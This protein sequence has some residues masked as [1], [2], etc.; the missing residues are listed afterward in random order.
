MTGFPPDESLLQCI[1]CSDRLS[2]VQSSVFACTRCLRQYPLHRGILLAMDAL[3][4]S[5]RTAAHFYD[6]PAWPRYRWRERAALTLVGGEGRLRRRLLDAVQNIGSARLLDVGIGDGANMP[7][8]DQYTQVY[9]IDIS[10]VQLLACS[11][12]Y[13]HRRLCLTLAAAERMPFRDRSFDHA[14]S[15][16]AFNLFTDRRR[17]LVEIARVVKPGGTVLIVDETPQL[18]KTLP[19]RYIGLPRL[20]RWL[21]AA[22]VGVGTE[23]SKLLEVHADIDVK[24]DAVATLH[25]VRLQYLLAGTCYRLTA[26]VP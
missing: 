24:A 19:G 8:L 15:I 3:S 11:E 17:A 9:G 26:T 2:R 5:N 13:H 16:G 23:F 7:F 14:I 4:G 25:D 18:V 22:I 12:A 6:G 1:Q 10:N 20:D 21:L